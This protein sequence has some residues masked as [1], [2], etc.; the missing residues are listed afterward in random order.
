MCN[1]FEDVKA[2]GRETKDN[3]DRNMIEREL[4]RLEHYS[5]RFI[6][7]RKSV[8]YAEREVEKIKQQ[9]ARALQLNPRYQA[10]DFQ[11]L[12]DIAK[13]VV[14]ARRAHSYTYAIGFYLCGVQKQ[15][16]FEFI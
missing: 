15:V 1:T 2:A 6:E 9:I 7:H 10:Q 16:F 12:L 4:Q 13:L 14:A 11:F 3:K 5:T 8:V